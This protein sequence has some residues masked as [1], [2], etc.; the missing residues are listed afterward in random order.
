MGAGAYISVAAALFAMGLLGLLARR[1]LLACAVSLALALSGAALGFA[2]LARFGSE[3]AHRPPPFAY[4]LIV[5][6]ALEVL[7][8]L[9]LALRAAPPAAGHPAAGDPVPGD[10]APRRE[11]LHPLSKCPSEPRE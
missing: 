3:P 5:L 10:P 1:T 4:L 11:D 9:G 7:A 2:A 6:A 8:A